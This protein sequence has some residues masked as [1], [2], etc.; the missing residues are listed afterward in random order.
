MSLRVALQVSRGVRA[1]STAPGKKGPDMSSFLQRVN[2]L[3]GKKG[4]KDLRKSVADFKPLPDMTVRKGGQDGQNSQRNSQKGQGQRGRGPRTSAAAGSGSGAGAGAGAG[5][6][7]NSR[8][9]PENRPPPSQ[10]KKTVGASTAAIDDHLYESVMTQTSANETLDLHVDRSNRYGAAAQRSFQRRGSTPRVGRGAG[11]QNRGGQNRGQNRSGPRA[12]FNRS[13][14]PG[15]KNAKNARRKKTAR[16]AAPQGAGGSISSE[17]ALQSLQRQLASSQFA[18]VE[19]LAPHTLVSTMSPL[20]ATSEGRMWTA[21][22]QRLLR[23]RRTRSKVRVSQLVQGAYEAN[24]LPSDSST[25]VTNALNASSTLP[26]SAKVTIANV[27]AGRAPIA[28]LRK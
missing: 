22:Q 10:R 9:S 27:A 23:G 14:K 12:G 8:F 16:D 2:A 20:A 5:L 26:L 13:G 3:Y 11:N 1:Y 17:E 21:V 15:A 19:Q 18:Q 7:K 28:S 6:K 25:S 24:T 4:E